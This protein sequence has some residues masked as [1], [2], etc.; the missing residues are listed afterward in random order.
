MSRN[1]NGLKL[2]ALGA[3]GF[4]TALPSPMAT[5]CSCKSSARRSLS[6]GYRIAGDCRRAGDGGERDHPAVAPTSGSRR[7][8]SSSAV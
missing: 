4:I 3:A 7:A 8:C 2:L 1:T 6:L 5:L